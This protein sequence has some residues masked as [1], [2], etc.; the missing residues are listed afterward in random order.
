MSK[1]KRDRSESSERKKKKSRRDDSRDRHKKKS[2]SRD[3]KKDDSRD[4]RRGRDRNRR[5]DD[6]GNHFR[7]DS[8]PK[9]HEMA[10]GFMAA[11]ATMGGGANV[12]SILSSIQSM[13]MA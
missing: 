3:R 5:G 9:E 12:H 11:A 8:P 10:P 4:R 13:S 1:R 2:R 6:N 7:F